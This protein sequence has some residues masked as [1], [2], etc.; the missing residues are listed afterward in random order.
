MQTPP[1]QAIANLALGFGTKIPEQPNQKTTVLV[2]SPQDLPA[3]NTIL[4]D[5]HDGV[6]K[7]EEAQNTSPTTSP[8]STPVG[9]P[10]VETIDLVTSPSRS[11]LTANNNAEVYSEKVQNLP[12]TLVPITADDLNNSPVVQDKTSPS[13]IT[14]FKQHELSP[15]NHKFI[16]GLN[17]ELDR[18]KAKATNS[19]GWATDMFW[20]AN[21][22]SKA[23]KVENAIADLQEINGELSDEVIIEAINDN[24][25]SLYQALN[26]HTGYLFGQ[27]FSGLTIGSSKQWVS[28]DTRAILNLKE[29]IEQDDIEVVNLTKGL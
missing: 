22:Q 4:E 26:Q 3:T 20:H 18:L 1:N 19:S 29:L 11:P 14:I 8:Q 17:A 7:A 16:D 25:S 12:V 23:N 21:Y 9:S 15:K 28:Q 10:K 6:F 13:P 2:D 5:K 27:L 24:S